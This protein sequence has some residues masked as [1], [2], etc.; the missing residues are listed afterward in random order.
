MKEFIKD[1]LEGFLDSHHGILSDIKET[2]RDLNL[3]EVAINLLTLLC[4]IVLYFINLLFYIGS[5][6]VVG[7]MILFKYVRDKLKELF[8]GR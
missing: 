4:L 3:R 5:T 8:N 7:S 6:I 2:M 1:Q